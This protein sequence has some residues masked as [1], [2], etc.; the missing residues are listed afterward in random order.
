[1]WVVFLWPS[2]QS[3]IQEMFLCRPW[4]GFCGI[5]DTRHRYD[6]WI[7]EA[8]PYCFWRSRGQTVDPW[9]TRIWTSL[10]HLYPD[11]FPVVNTI[12]LYD[13]WLVESVYMEELHLW[14]AE[15]RLY[16]NFQL[17]GWLALLIPL[18]C[19]GQLYCEQEHAVGYILK[20]GEE[21]GMLG[22]P[23]QGGPLQVG[24][25][26]NIAWKSC[27]LSSMHILSFHPWVI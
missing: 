16:T 4:A 5:S 1:M 3:Y 2:I 18:V 13:L 24:D 6:S 22:E 8:Y 17:R 20:N 7:R 12:V 25:K 27:S 23:L 21:D 15:C 14:R 19:R 10:V 9:T 26:G 11:F